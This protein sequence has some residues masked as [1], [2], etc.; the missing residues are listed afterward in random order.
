MTVNNKLHVPDVGRMK[1]EAS[2]L[3][4]SFDQTELRKNLS[5]ESKNVQYCA[6]IIAT[7]YPT[8]LV[9]EGLLYR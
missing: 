9:T 3:C 5:K 1:V 4:P 2:I 8:T 7:L 6:K